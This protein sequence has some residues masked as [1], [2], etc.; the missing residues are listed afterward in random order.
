MSTQ[1]LT[2]TSEKDTWYPNSIPTLE[3][4]LSFLIKP[5]V[6]SNAL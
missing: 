1:R 4:Y 6:S 2:L 3:N 5:N